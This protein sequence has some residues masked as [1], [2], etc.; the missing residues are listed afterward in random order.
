MWDTVLLDAVGS[1]P[2]ALSD[3]A[4]LAQTHAT[5]AHLTSPHLTS[6]HVVHGTS[7]YVSSRILFCDDVLL[8]I[9][10]LTESVDLSVGYWLG[11]SHGRVALT[12]GWSC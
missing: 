6:P 2:L 4:E 3:S 11:A 12:A 5:S 10:R 7:L 8:M 9:P 1:A